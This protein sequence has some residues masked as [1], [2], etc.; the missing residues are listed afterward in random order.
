MLKLKEG[1]VELYKKV[2]SA[3]PS[4]V[5]DALKK[6]FE[7][8]TNPHTKESVGRI[9]RGIKSSRI[10]SR[11]LCLDTGIPFFFVW[12]PR[13][14][15]QQ[16]VREVIVDATRL[17]TK[18]VPL[19]PNAVDV[20][21]GVNSGDNTGLYFP[22][23]H[24]EETD[25][26]S[27]TIDLML[28]G[29]ECENLGS[30]YKLPTAFNVAN[31]PVSERRELTVERNLEGVKSCVIDAVCK[32]KGRGCPPYTI[33]I[34]I[35]GARDQVAYLS[36]RQLC[37]R[38][39]VPNPDDRLATVEAEIVQEVNEFGRT[40]E[41]LSRNVTA[42]GVRVAVAHRHPQS[43]FVDVSFSCWA[44]RKARLVW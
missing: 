17:A 29:S 11:P 12:V 13:G 18:K 20:L 38:I 34:A 28:Q 7:A 32:A 26:N 36:R 33:G 19:S 42:L 41:G 2:A 23:I 22:L 1:I 39:D 15:S 14:L 24:I 8:E 10:A 16:H 44:N 43:Y 4:D 25:K 27:L 31:G 35:G 6:A 40:A 21:S 9:L 3:I 30:I 37:G 5:E